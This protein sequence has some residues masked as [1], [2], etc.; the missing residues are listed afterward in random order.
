MEHFRLTVPVAFIIFNRPENTRKVFERIREARPETL[1]VIADGPRPERPTDAEKCQATRQIIETIDWECQVHTDFAAENLGCKRRVSSGLDWVFRH[2]AEA[3]ILEDDCLPDPSFFRYCAELLERYR[4]DERVVS[5]SGDNFQ[6]GIQR[7]SASYYFSRHPHVWGWASWR[8]VW[9]QY[10]IEMKTWP[11][12]RECSWLNTVFEDQLMARYWSETFESVYQ[13]KI[14]TWDH[15]W[16][17]NCWRLNGVT[18]LPEV[19]LISN[20]GFG[21]EATHTRRKSQF[22][23]MK[24]GRLEF[25]LAHPADVIRNIEADKFTERQNYRTDLFARAK[26]SLRRWLTI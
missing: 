13:G 26:R 22:S 15:Q 4:E 16:T 6:G 17:Y 19:N 25:P 20:I 24:T 23:E 8:R 7:T 12:M 11:E 1:L 2:H 10:D 18:A 5:I 21:R 9:R 14:D 3:I